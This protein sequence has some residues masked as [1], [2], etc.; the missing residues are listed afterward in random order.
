M[1]ADVTD[2]LGAVWT[3]YPPGD[4]VTPLPARPQDAWFATISKQNG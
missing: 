2:L 1:E 3:V 4:M